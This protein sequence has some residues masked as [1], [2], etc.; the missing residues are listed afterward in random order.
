MNMFAKREIVFIT[1]SCLLVLSCASSAKKDRAESS[2]AVASASSSTLSDRVTLSLEDA[3]L[4]SIVKQIGEKTGGRFAVMNG[5]EDLQIAQVRFSNADF[6]TVA[7]KLSKETKCALQHCPSY[8]FFYWP[9][10]EQLTNI[11]LSSVSSPQF[12]STVDMIAFGYG[13]P[14][15]AV[16]SWLGQALGTTIVADNAVAEAKCG[17]I[18]LRDI[19]LNE[20]VEAILKSARVAAIEV[21]CPGEYLFISAPGNP[22]PRSCLLNPETLDERQRNYLETKVKVVLP[23]PPREQGKVRIE[24]HAVPLRDVLPSLSEQLGIL[25]TAEEGMKDIPIN[26]AAFSGVSVRTVLDLLVRQWLANDFGYQFTS[27]RIVLRRRTSGERVVNPNTDT[28]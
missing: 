22:N 17:E 20:A 25:V 7:E 28:K 3:T 19:P 10:Y 2:K 4:A 16:F 23:Q 24:P 1:C 9:G 14:L 21:E 6:K 11:S 5:L 12:V 15:Y 27:D 18:A 26:P 8:F 13:M